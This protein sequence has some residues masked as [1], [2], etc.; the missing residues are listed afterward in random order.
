M[1]SCCKLS[2]FKTITKPLSLKK[3]LTRLED[4]QLT[5]RLLFDSDPGER[6]F[7]PG[8]NF[9]SA[10]VLFEEKIIFFRHEISLFDAVIVI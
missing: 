3:R 10:N 6:L 2:L 5:N 9:L 7:H 1:T 8:L 4:T